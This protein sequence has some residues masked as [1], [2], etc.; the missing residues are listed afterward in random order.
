MKK[1][2]T[3]LFLA[4]LLC[5]SFAAC[6]PA[7]VTSGAAKADYPISVAGITLNA[8]PKGVVAISPS[9]ADVV[10]A[11]GYEMSLKGRSAAC[12]QA[13]LAALP[14][15]ELSA[16]A[17]AQKIKDAGAD[18]VLL[19]AKPSEEISK[20]L[21]NA[22]VNALV[23]P[24]A[25]T[26][27]EFEKL[28]TQ[29]G[30]ALAGGK[31]GY[32]KG[33]KTGQDTFKLMDDI[34]RLIPKHDV[35][36]TACY[37]YDIGRAATYDTLAGKIFDY[38]GA[39]N[40]AQSTTGGDFSAESLKISNPNFIFCAPGVKDKLAADA[41][42]KDLDAVKNGKVYELDPGEMQWQ[43]DSIVQAASF[44]AGTIYPELNQASSAVSSAAPTTSGTASG[45]TPATTSSGTASGAASSTAAATNYNPLKQGDK[46]TDVL[47]MQKRLDQLGYMK[48][49]NYTNYNGTYDATTAKAVQDFQF[50]NGLVVNGTADSKTLQKLYASDAKP[51]R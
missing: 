33:Q 4:A 44:I 39:V 25:T 41:T 28:Y 9:L 7:D 43:G 46:G 34:S 51:R 2:L 14:V 27:E 35:V 49:Y 30:S 24:M 12:T 18:L 23:L 5:F 10:L 17:D 13:D 40:C 11:L 47:N 15:L 38:T 1:R 8:K 42:L 36:I 6:A 19:D 29:L 32:T 22:G 45:T 20:A 21:Q 31:T 3:A 48:E 16:A 50:K 37:L 26:R